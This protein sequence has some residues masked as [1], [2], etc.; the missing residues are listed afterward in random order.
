[1]ILS[2]KLCMQTLVCSNRPLIGT[3]LF[4]V[5]VVGGQTLKSVFGES[6][7]S[8]FVMPPSLGALEDRL[9]GRGTENEESLKERLAKSERE[10]QSASAFDLRLV[11]DQL[12]LAL[13]EASDMVGDF[14]D[15][16]FH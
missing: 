11:N 3:P 1:M 8:I 6:A 2:A 16:G 4:D 14:L 12:D 10:M 15:Q 9:R 13:A 7:L 5:D